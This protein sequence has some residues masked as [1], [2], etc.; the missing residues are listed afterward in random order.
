MLRVEHWIGETVAG[1]HLEVRPLQEEEVGIVEGCFPS[2]TP[3]KHRERLTRQR[4]GEVV[5]LIA[6]LAQRP[7][8]H[9]LVKLKDA[10]HAPIAFWGRGGPYLEDLWV[11]PDRRS[12]GIGSRLLEEAERLAQERGFDRIG[13]RVVVENVRARALYARHGYLD[14]G[15]GEYPTAGSY[16][17]ADG[18]AR[19]WSTLSRY[20]V[21]KLTYKQA[22]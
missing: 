13:L 20:L 14:S 22:A 6:W 8:G 3:L 16:V 21:K 4:R 19:A 9:V 10:P 7:V 15:L 17:G 18:K 5:Y 12:Q 1:Q 2:S 11:A